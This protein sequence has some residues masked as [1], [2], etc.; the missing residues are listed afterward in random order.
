LANI[1]GGKRTA[2]DA[3][4]DIDTQVQNKLGGK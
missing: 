1:Y 4:V 2:R 3:A